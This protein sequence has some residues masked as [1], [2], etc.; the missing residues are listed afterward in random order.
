MALGAERGAVERMILREGGWLAAL[1]IALGMGGALAAARLMRS[2]LFDVT[3][4]DIS[5]LAA[6]GAVVCVAAL[7][8]SFLPARRAALVNPTEAL[9]AE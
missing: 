8:A 4:W 5:T 3:A 9:R 7:A 6:V 2:L 1:G